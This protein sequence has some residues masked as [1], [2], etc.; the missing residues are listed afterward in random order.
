MRT[1]TIIDRNLLAEALDVEG[2]RA[3]LLSDEKCLICGNELI[4]QYSLKSGICGVCC[5]E[6][7]THIAPHLACNLRTQDPDFNYGH[8]EEFYNAFERALRR[9]D[10]RGRK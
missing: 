5:A 1:G 4:A 2:H 3:T 8:G 7:G 10:F 9:G 6:N